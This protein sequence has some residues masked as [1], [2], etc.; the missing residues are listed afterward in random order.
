MR[1]GRHWSVASTSKKPPGDEGGQH[2]S[3]VRIRFGYSAGCPPAHQPLPTGSEISTRLIELDRAGAEGMLESF[4][5]T[6]RAHSRCNDSTALLCD[7]STSC[8][9]SIHLSIAW[10]EENPEGF[11]TRA[12][13][14]VESYCMSLPMLGGP[15]GALA[16]RGRRRNTPRTRGGMSR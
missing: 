10:N 1:P 6:R 3:E 13:D 11:R 12:L 5:S 14:G 16:G 2:F 9:S 8:A 7:M 15:A 4:I